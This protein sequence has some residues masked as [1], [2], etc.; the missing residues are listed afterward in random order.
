MTGAV[1][2][3][4]FDL[5]RGRALKHEAHQAFE[6][7]AGWWLGQA[8]RVA[9]EVCREK[10]SVTSDDVLA[11]VGLPNGVHH[12]VVGTIFKE[13]CWVRVGFTQTKRPEGHARLIG[14]WRLKGRI[15]KRTDWRSSK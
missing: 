6:E 14:V 3:V 8:R 13:R 7:R 15:Y 2:G 12:N 1:Q 10:G 4:L 5:D 11:V 9:R